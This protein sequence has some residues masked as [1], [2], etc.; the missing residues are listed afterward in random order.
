VRR[1]AL[2]LLVATSSLAA[3]CVDPSAPNDGA[4]PPA[5]GVPFDAQR[6]LAWVEAQIRDPDTGQAW[7]RIPGTTESRRAADL[8]H[9][10]LSA[11]NWSVGF[12]DFEG[13]IEGRAVAMRN[14]VAELA[15]TSSRTV[16][17]AAHYDTR[18]CA[19]KD[20]DPERRRDPV[21]GANDGASGVAVLLELARV[22]DAQRAN[23]S[24]R[25]YLFDGEDQGDGGLGC[26]AGTDWAQG[27]EFAAA[28]LTDAERARIV[29]MILVDLVGDR[30][31]E[32]AR[33][34]YSSVGA[35]RALQDRIWGMA[36]RL[37]HAHFVDRPATPVLDDHVPF[38]RR[39][40]PAVDIIHLDQG[41]DPF[42]DTHHTT[43]D[44][45]DRISVRALRAVG[46]TV[47]ATIRAMDA[48]ASS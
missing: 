20:P 1:V 34:G 42:P 24:F 39:G 12:Q 48:E 4:P 40:I 13:T 45:L 35:S 46:E 9:A 25:L 31:A 16:L 44:D 36:A 8:F 37:G 19:D 47:L 11:R 30:E 33:E 28:A 2:A 22:L 23:F 18:I 5:P 10:E 17:L 14:V 43:F 41:A 3:G 7:Y 32:F 15:G 21:V 29:G 38:Q 26:G 27:S 6:A